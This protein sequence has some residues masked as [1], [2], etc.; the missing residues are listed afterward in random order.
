MDKKNKIKKPKLT[1]QTVYNEIAERT[2]VPA[3][4][5]ERVMIA[6]REMVVE[7][8]SNMV[9][10]P[11]GNLGTFGFSIIPPH[12]FVE[13]NGFY[14]GKPVVYYKNHSDGHIEVKW[15]FGPIFK[16]TMKEL[17]KIPYGSIPALPGTEER[18]PRSEVRIDYDAM[19][20][21]ILLNKL[22]KNDDNNIDLQKDIEE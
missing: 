9:E 10:I 7:S 1:N 12:E 4:T 19:M 6:Y 18:H 8:L 11:F 2:N 15:R 17:T 16:K 13:W 20:K 22:S 3:W 5:V 14:Q 21:E